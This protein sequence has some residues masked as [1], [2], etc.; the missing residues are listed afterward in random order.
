MTRAEQVR[1]IVAE[2]IYNSHGF[3]RPFDHPKT[4]RIWGRWLNDQTGALI[5]ALLECI[6]EPSEEMNNRGWAVGDW[7]LQD[8]DATSPTR[9]WRAMLAQLKQ[10]IGGT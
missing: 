9:I 6:E 1:R 8:D 3:K 7:D 2:A 5:A 4:Q 10:E